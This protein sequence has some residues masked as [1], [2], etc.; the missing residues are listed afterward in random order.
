[1]VE[2]STAPRDQSIH[3]PVFMYAPE[4]LHMLCWPMD[5][6][7]REL[8][9]YTEFTSRGATLINVVHSTKLTATREPVGTSG[10]S[11]KRM[12]GEHKA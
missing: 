4:G 10:W 6:G 3:G 5:R 12:I 1:M 11:E 2:P 7:K 8:D 9:A